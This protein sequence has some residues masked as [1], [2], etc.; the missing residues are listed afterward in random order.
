MYD[1]F[2]SELLVILVK[3]HIKVPVC[4]SFLPR[5]KLTQIRIILLIWCNLVE[6]SLKKYSDPDTLQ[7]HH[8][9]YILVYS[10]TLWLAVTRIKK[11]LSTMETA[12]CAQK[13][14]CSNY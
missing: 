12:R 13:L 8:Y 9:S 14:C 5:K 7:L 2:L 4:Y 11:C 6:K 3:S 10:L 1:A